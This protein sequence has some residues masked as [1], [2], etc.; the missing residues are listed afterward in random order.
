M[1][2]PCPECGA[3]GYKVMYAGIPMRICEHVDGPW[4]W[5]GG[6]WLMD[7]LPFNGWFIRYES[8]WPTLWHWLC[9]RV[10]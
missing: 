9:G 4:I 8:Y 6:A 5:G 1:N 2:K 3:K 10:E 7:Y